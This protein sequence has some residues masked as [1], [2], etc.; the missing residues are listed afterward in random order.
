MNLDE[1]KE[2]PGFKSKYMPKLTEELIE[3][4]NFILNLVKLVKYR[5]INDSFQNKLTNDLKMI[6]KTKSIIV[7]ACKTKSN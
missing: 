7:P 6:C 2:A 4:E 5:K 1:N 3:F